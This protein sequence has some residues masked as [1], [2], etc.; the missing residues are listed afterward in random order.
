M[1]PIARNCR[2]RSGFTLV[3]LLVVIGIIAV[4]VSLLLPSLNKARESAKRVSCAAQLRQVCS[5]LMLYANANRGWFPNVGSNAFN[6]E[7][8][9]AD[10]S[11]YTA[12]T[13]NFPYQ[14]NRGALEVLSRYG[15]IRNVWYCPSTPE[16]NSDTTYN[17]YLTAPSG[18]SFIGYN[19]FAGRTA[20]SFIKD[21]TKPRNGAAST[22]DGFEEV[23]N[24]MLTFAVRQ[25]QRPHYK[26]LATDYVRAA[27]TGLAT[28][29][30]F[31]TNL[32]D[33]Y[34][35][36]NHLFGSE[37]MANFMSKGK[38]GA[39]V[40]YTDGHVDWVSQNDMGQRQQGPTKGMRIY[41]QGASTFYRYYF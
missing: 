33:T 1:R 5:S 23:P 8:R 2:V 39:N 26:V 30:S 27:S 4:L 14:A 22:Y 7:W 25:G 9:N 15:A 38:G 31:Q 37:T 40:G 12:A 17:R 11:A 20:L 35:A 10:G 21:S 24:G 32:G 13:A 18:V 16:I 34:A 41:V 19:V 6:S 29:G 36:A 28:P 3:E